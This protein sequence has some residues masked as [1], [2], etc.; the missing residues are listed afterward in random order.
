MQQMG[1]TLGYDSLLSRTSTG[2]CDNTTQAH[3]LEL[4]RLVRRADVKCQPGVALSDLKAMRCRSST[5]RRDTTL[6]EVELLPDPMQSHAVG[7]I[8]GR[9]TDSLDRFE[10]RLPA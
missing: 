4:R 8:P 9:L 3:R 1:I 7:M 6:T 2:I 10:V 5:I